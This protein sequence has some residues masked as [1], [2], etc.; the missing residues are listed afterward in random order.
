MWRSPAHDELVGVVPVDQTDVA[1]KV[2]AE[3]MSRTPAWAKGLPLDADAFT[4]ERYSK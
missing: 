2:F 1:L 3:E 4:A